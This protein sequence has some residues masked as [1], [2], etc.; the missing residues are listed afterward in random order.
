MTDRPDP[1]IVMLICIYT[2]MHFALIIHVSDLMIYNT[3]GSLAR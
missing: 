2:I 3:D 1:T